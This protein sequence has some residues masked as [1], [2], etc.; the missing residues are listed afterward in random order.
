[1]GRV[2]GAAMR[3]SYAVLLL[4]FIVWYCIAQDSGM[5]SSDDDATSTLSHFFPEDEDSPSLSNTTSELPEPASDRAEA[6]VRQNAVSI[7]RAHPGVFGERTSLDVGTVENVCKNEF[8]DQCTTLIKEMWDLAAAEPCGFLSHELGFLRE[9][10]NR[11]DRI[12]APAVKVLLKDMCNGA[13]NPNAQSTD[14]P[15]ELDA[16]DE[17]TLKIEAKIVANANNSKY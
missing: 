1:M 7:L 15:S 9:Q 6:Y 8:V 16:A 13:A 12:R 14:E 17:L 11:D 4:L 10:L 3:I 2:A 5:S